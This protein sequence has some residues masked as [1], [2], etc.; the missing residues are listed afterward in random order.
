MADF[1]DLD[2]VLAQLVLAIGAALFVGNAYALIMD[3]RSRKPKGMEGELRRSRAWWLT[4]V[5]AV[6]AWWG[7]GSM[8]T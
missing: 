5:G 2:N 3:H 8:L 1:F 4:A 6:M 7:L